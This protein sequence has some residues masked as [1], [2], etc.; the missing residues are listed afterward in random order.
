MSCG[1]VRVRKVDA[2]TCVHSKA[3]MQSIQYE[4]FTHMTTLHL[5]NV[6]LFPPSL[7]SLMRSEP[8]NVERSSHCDVEILPIRL[9]SATKAL[10]IFQN[11]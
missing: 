9:I 7:I 1:E 2:A 3:D 6:S 8:K 5:G 4:N 10:M 11:P